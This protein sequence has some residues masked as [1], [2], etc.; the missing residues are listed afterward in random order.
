MLLQL[1]RRL[2]FALL[3]LQA[4]AVLG[5]Q[6]RLGWAHD[7]T[8]PHHAAHASQ[9]ADAT[10]HAGLAPVARQDAAY[11]AQP[12][13]AEHAAHA[14][15]ANAA[16][17]TPHSSPDGSNTQCQ[18]MDPECGPAGVVAMLSLA[19][20]LKFTAAERARDESTPAMPMAVAR[21]GAYL[22]HRLPFPLAP[23]RLDGRL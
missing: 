1:A 9:S 13:H 16:E 14:A 11:A 2:R 19:S 10:P 6:G 17:A 8:C 20:V 3:P 15:A 12:S 7:P 18:C 23:P 21:P 22:T 5:F 4:V